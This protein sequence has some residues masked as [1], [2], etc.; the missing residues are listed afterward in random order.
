[1]WKSRSLRSV[2]AA[3]AIAAMSMGCIAHAAE[4]SPSPEAKVVKYEAVAHTKATVQVPFSVYRGEQPA[5]EA[6]PVQTYPVNKQPEVAV[7]ASKAYA[8]SLVASIPERPRP[9]QSVDL[10]IV[11]ISTSTLGAGAMPSRM[12]TDPDPSPRAANFVDTVL[13]AAI[14]RYGAGL[15]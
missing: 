14:G 2:V 5:V 1:M 15:V 13:S 7:V 9:A 6:K 10:N 3:L 12:Q 4:P 11:M 8:T